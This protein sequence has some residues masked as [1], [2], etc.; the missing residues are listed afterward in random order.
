MHSEMYD[1]VVSKVGLNQQNVIV[2]ANFFL[3]NE[4]TFSWP[5]ICGTLNSRFTHPFVH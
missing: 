3:Q 5:L 4:I 2:K 1:L